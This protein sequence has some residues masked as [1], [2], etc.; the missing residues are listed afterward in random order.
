MSMFGYN[1]LGFGSIAG[2]AGPPDLDFTVV[3]SVAT[4]GAGTFNNV[5]IGT[6]NTHR[7]VVISA[8][9]GAAAIPGEIT[10]GGEAMSVVNSTTGQYIAFKKVPTG[11]T[12]TIVIT[13]GGS[14]VQQIYTLN[15]LNSGA[16]DSQVNYVFA[17]TTV[18]SES[19]TLSTTVS[20]DGVFIWGGFFRIG[21]GPG[22][23]F[24]DALSTDNSN[25]VTVVSTGTSGGP[26]RQGYSV[27]TSND[28]KFARYTWS[29]TGSKSANYQRGAAFAFFKASE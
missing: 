27:C 10:I 1:T 12:A 3:G 9:S 19:F 6:A 23:S 18:T 16:S 15:T 8:N 25:G 20:D 21:S 11:T 28:T 22:G 4:R 26:N 5:A 2:T 13:G 24:S 29:R 14:F 7:M 17:T